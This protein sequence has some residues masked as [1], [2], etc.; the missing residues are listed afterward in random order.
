MTS[1]NEEFL[2]GLLREVQ[3]LL[4]KAVDDDHPN[5]GLINHIAEYSAKVAKLAEEADVY[6]G[7]MPIAK[8]FLAN[9]REHFC[10]SVDQTVYKLYFDKVFDEMVE[11]GAKDYDV[12]L[13]QL[14]DVLGTFWS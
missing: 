14:K 10:Q 5:V 9:K 13:E 1:K 7:T 6:P 11:Q 8:F 4:Q 2:T 3:V 12:P